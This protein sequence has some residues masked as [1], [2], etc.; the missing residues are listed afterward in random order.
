MAINLTEANH[1]AMNRLL[2]G[3]LVAHSDGNV[4][5]EQARAALAHVLTAAAIGNETELR[6]WFEP[7]R[8]QR[9]LENIHDV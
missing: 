5:L 3:I 6:E 9:W 8:L 4:S 2:D 1:R 7:E